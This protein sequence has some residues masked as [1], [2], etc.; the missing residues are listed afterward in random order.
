MGHQTA[1][2]LE[3][4]VAE[5]RAEVVIEII[6]RGLRLHGVLVV[7]E[8]QDAGAFLEIVFVLDLADDLFQ[9]VLDGHQT[10]GRAIFVDDDGHVIAAGAELLQ[11][12]VQALALRHEYRRAQHVAHVEAAFAPL[13]VAEQILRQQDADHLALVVGDH[14]EARMRGLDHGRQEFLQ[15]RIPADHRHLRAWH[16]DIA[17]AQVGDLQH[18]LDHRQGVGIQQGSGARLFYQ[19]QQLLAV[20]RPAR[21]A[22]QQAGQ[23][24]P[25]ARADGTSIF[26]HKGGFQSWED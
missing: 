23:P 24:R 21:G 3:L 4:L 6:D 17:H 7:A 18:A 20:I 2:G 12:H 16:H 9:Y 13:A 22:D 1:D 26:I 10:A 8:L 11:Q 19:V 5:L 15:R 25:E 14:R